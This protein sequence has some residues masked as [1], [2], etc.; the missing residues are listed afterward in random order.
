M[1]APADRVEARRLVAAVEE[2]LAEATPTSYRDDTKPPLV[3]DALPV[4]QPGLPPMSQRATDASALMLSGSVL[5]VAVGGAATA[6][7]WASG[8]ADPVVIGLVAGAPPAF[9]LALSRVFRRAKETVEAAPA[10]HHHHYSG[11]VHQDQRTSR[12]NGVW[13]KTNNK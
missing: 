10:E 7:L 8:N 2:A 4:A 1:T 5:T 6:V 9:M 3:G 13:A 11:P 12:T